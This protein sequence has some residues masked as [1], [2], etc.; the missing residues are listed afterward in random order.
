MAVRT[1]KKQLAAKIDGSY[2]AIIHPD[3][4]FDL[5]EDPNWIDVHKY[6][7]PDEI[8]EGEIGK[9]WRRAFCRDHGSKEFLQKPEAAK[10][11]Q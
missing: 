7:K 1:L 8:F 6:A 3:I 10:S 11:R 5:T 4:A 9:N 2:W